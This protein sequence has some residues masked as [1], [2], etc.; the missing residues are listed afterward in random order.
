[1]TRTL[2]AVFALATFTTACVTEDADVADHLGDQAPPPSIDLALRL[3]ASDVGCAAAGTDRVDVYLDGE[4]V[5]E[6]APCS[7]LLTLELAQ[8]D[9]D[10]DVIAYSS[11]DPGPGWYGLAKVKFD[12]SA[13]TAHL[14]PIAAP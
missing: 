9:A 3:G 1:M 6:G 5:L 11:T 13:T 14:E 10:L 8:A 12:Q 7:A 2:L 4:F